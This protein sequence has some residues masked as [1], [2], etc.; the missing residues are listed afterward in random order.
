MNDEPQRWA[1]EAYTISTDRAAANSRRVGVYEADARAPRAPAFV[2][3]PSGPSA[4]PEF[5]NLGVQLE[6]GSLEPREH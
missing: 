6:S 4:S 5:P 2:A 3:P 1:R